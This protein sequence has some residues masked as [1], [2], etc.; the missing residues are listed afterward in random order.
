MKRPIIVVGAVLVLATVCGVLVLV[1][2]VYLWSAIADQFDQINQW[3]A[4]GGTCT[5]SA[6][7]P[8]TATGLVLVRR[9]FKR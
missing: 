7:L 9:K 8:L 5:A 6:M 1:G 2:C 3:A 4:Q